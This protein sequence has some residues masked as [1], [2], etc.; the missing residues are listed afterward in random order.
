[1]LIHEHSKNT[2]Y[3]VHI[4][5]EGNSSGHRSQLPKIILS[6]NPLLT[7]YKL[8]G[9]VNTLNIKPTTNLVHII[10]AGNSGHRSQVPKIVLSKYPVTAPPT[11]RTLP[12]R[13]D[14]TRED[15]AAA[16]TCGCVVVWLCGDC[17]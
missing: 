3:L 10:G 13:V 7:D 1:M 12:A 11:P 9:A 8:V 6:I 17:V 15:G 5:A 14:V 4:S 2:T 16:E